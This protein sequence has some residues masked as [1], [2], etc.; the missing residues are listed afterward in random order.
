VSRSDLVNA[1]VCEQRK[2]DLF[3]IRKRFMDTIF[4]MVRFLREVKFLDDS[5]YFGIAQSLSVEVTKHSSMITS[6]ASDLKE[7]LKNKNYGD[8]I[9]EL[10]VGVISIS[11]QFA[12]FF[13]PRSP[14]YTKG[15]KSY[16][17]EDVQYELYN[18]FEYEVRLDF[19]TFKN[20]NEL[21]AKKMIAQ[22]ILSSFDVFKKFKDFNR[23]QFKSDLET[24]FKSKGWL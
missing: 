24:L 2:I 12:Q 21:E 16:V 5:M 17:K 6:L 10:T 8:E 14:K 23:D 3:L 22:G 20:A 18:S 9:A 7:F 11:P 19:E 13:K 15:H 4:K 1:E